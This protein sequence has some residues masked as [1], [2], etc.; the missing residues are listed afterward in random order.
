[1]GYY[2]QKSSDG[3]VEL[4][5]DIVDTPIWKDYDVINCPKVVR[6]IAFLYEAVQKRENYYQENSPTAFGDVKYEFQV[7]KVLGI[8]QAE[9]ISEATENGC[10]VFRRNGNVLLRVDKVN[11]PRSYYEDM[12]DIRKTLKEVFG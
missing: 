2:I 7:G 9:D 4:L 6:V 5:P 1:M 3:A 10:I 8:L 11:K 12:T